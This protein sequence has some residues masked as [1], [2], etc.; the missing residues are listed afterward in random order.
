MPECAAERV[1]QSELSP[2]TVEDDEP[3][4][5]FISH[6]SHLMPDGRLATAAFRIADITK[7]NGYSVMRLSGVSFEIY[8]T[9]ARR[10]LRR[11]EGWCPLGVAVA[12]CES[13]RAIRDQRGSRLFCVV[14]DG[15]PNFELHALIRPRQ[16]L[17]KRAARLLRTELMSQFVFWPG[18]DHFSV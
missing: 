8:E 7:S 11:P 16:R 9:T 3:L 1:Q 15:L 4:G 6:K 12:E 14:D 10:Q 18:A 5:R 2:G 17:N 13:V